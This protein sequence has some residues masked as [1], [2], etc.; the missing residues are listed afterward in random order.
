MRKLLH[1]LLIISILP[2]SIACTSESK[3]SDSTADGD[4]PTMV[5]KRRDDGTLSSINPMDEDGYMHGVKTNFYE[6]GKTVHS[7]VT[8]DHG[9]KHGPAIWYYKNG[10]IYEHTNFTLNRRSGLTKRYYKTG[11]LMEELTYDTGEEQPGT[12]KYNKKGE[13]IK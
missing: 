11:E 5:K 8:Y 2:G 6:D 12:K 7:K 13:L 1:I 10:Q 4:Q 9:R 3:K